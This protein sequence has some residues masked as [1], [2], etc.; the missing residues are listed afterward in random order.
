MTHPPDSLQI[1]PSTFQAAHA[2][3][4][5][6][7][8]IVFQ[9]EQGVAPALDWDGQDD[10]CHHLIA[11]IDQ[12]PV[13]VARLRPLETE[14]AKLERVAVLKPWRGQGIGKALV[15]TAIALVQTQ[16]IEIL[17]LHAQLPSVPFYES[18]G[19]TASG[20]PFLEA[21]IPHLKM[22]QSY[23]KSASP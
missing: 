10:Q 6:I 14:M 12:D 19:F 18:L 1:L 16:N 13:G 21:N 8:Q 2:D 17:V 20:D 5:R 22:Q 9:Q 15:Q 4:A 7:R 3:I 23:F 11:Y